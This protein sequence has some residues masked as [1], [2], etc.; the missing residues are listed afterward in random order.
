M[1]E[2]SLAMLQD[3]IFRVSDLNKPLYLSASCTNDA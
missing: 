1:T 2:E 3:L